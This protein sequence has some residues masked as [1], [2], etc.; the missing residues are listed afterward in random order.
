M[1]VWTLVLNAHGQLTTAT[2]NVKALHGTLWHELSEAS[3]QGFNA[4]AQNQGGMYGLDQVFGEPT[5][6]AVIAHA[7]AFK[8]KVCNDAKISAPKN[9]NWSRSADGGSLLEGQWSRGTAG[10]LSVA[11]RRTADI[12]SMFT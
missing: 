9:S 8:R 5:R 1:N 12:S 7:D 3:A 10:V 4:T 6:G 11:G 2:T